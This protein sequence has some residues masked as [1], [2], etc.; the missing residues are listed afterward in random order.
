LSSSTAKSQEYTRNNYDRAVT[1][2]TKFL[3][4]ATTFLSAFLLFQVQLIVSKHILPWFGGSA[5]VWTTSMLVFQLLLL[6]GYVYSHLIS[7]RLSPFAQAKL[8]MAL[9]AAVFLLV[10][11]L[12]FLW[13]SAITPGASWKPADSG[14]PVRDVAFTSPGVC[15][16]AILCSL[17][18]RPPTATLVRP[19]GRWRENLQTL[20]HLE[21]RLLSGTVEL[22]FRDGTGATHENAERH[23]VAAVLCVRGGLL[24]LRATRT[25]HTRRRCRGR[26]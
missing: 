4:A 15:G 3:F 25:P 1:G 6:C 16:P 7:A 14:H 10:F 11:T 13:P 18:Y 26:F 9:L 20:F 21:P 24:S 19:S 12:M 8:H 23:V 17:D 22:P 2:T 5:A